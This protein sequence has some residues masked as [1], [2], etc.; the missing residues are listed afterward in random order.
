MG[1]KKG[2][3]NN[4]DGRPVGCKGKIPLS[5][6][7]NIVDY[8]NDNFDSY[9]ERLNSL[10]GKDYVRCMTELIKLV[11]PRPLNEEESYSFNFHSEMINR[12]F[13]KQ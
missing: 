1:L 8:I 7:T 2:Q 5:V 10:E 3:T 13:N 4:P 11:V 9:I 12:L 6:K